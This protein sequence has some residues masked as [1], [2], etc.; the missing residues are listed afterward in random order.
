MPRPPHTAEYYRDWAEE[1]RRAAAEAKVPHCRE[2][3]LQAAEDYDGMANCVERF[4]K[5]KDDNH[6]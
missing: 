1:M 4:L 6:D 2:M 3:L 5:R